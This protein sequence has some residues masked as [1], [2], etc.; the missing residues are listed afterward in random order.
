MRHDANST[1]GH[2]HNAVASNGNF[3]VKTIKTAGMDSAGINNV[4]SKYRTR[5]DTGK[6]IN[7]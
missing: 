4:D 2:R 3:D 6:I 5:C 7:Q 1:R